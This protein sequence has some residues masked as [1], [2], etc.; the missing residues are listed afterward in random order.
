MEPAHE[1]V[2]G[3]QAGIASDD[4]S[5]QPQPRQILAADHRELFKTHPDRKWLY[6]PQ[7][8]W[9][10]FHADDLDNWEWWAC[11]KESPLPSVEAGDV[12]EELLRTMQR[13]EAA[14]RLSCAT[15]SAMSI[16]YNGG[17]IAGMK[18]HSDVVEG[19]QTHVVLACGVV[20]SQ[21][22]HGLSL[23]RSAQ[24]HLKQPRNQPGVNVNDEEFVPHYVRFNRLRP[25]T[26]SVGQRL[27][28]T[29]LRTMEGHSIKLSD[30]L[31]ELS[32]AP[33]GSTQQP[34]PVVVVSSSLT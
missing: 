18:S 4:I 1:E 30:V 14:L 22:E 13:Y 12:S 26:V 27:K 3:P 17:T 7:V 32:T 20:K 24:L 5:R 11:E 21:L 23:L 28:E 31:H 25:P 10:I 8:E 33:P 34:C 15:Q 9:N 6:K 2:V 16:I 19:L 29:E